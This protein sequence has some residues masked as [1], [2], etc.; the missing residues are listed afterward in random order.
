MTA[1]VSVA[2]EVSL[3][4]NNGLVSL[5]VGSLLYPASNGCLDLQG[6]TSD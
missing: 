3:T 6:K 4:I 1:L 5:L 2:N